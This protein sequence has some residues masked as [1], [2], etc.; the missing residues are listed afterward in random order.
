MS[1]THQTVSNDLVAEDP[2]P[3]PLRPALGD[4]PS[5]SGAGGVTISYE[6]RR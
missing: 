1:Y 5:A 4:T 3:P 2:E 6:V